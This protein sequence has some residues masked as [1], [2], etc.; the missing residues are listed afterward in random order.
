LCIFDNIDGEQKTITTK[1]FDLSELS[2]SLRF[3]SSDIKQ[4][5]QN[6]KR[7]HEIKEVWCQIFE[8]VKHYKVFNFVIEELE[9]KNKTNTNKNSSELNKQSKNLWHRTLTINLIEKNCN[10]IGLKLIPIIPAYS[11]FIGN[12]IHT[13]YV[14]PIAS[15]IEIGRRG[16]VKYLKGN[17]IYPCISLI[18][19]EKLLSLLG[20]ND[21]K[22][23]DSWTQLYR[24]I[25]R[26]RYR[27]VL[28]LDNVLSDK[29]LGNYK[30]KIRVITQ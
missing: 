20:E 30:S 15:A 29:Y 14:D 22:T 7:K 10:E 8:L 5:K 17:S 1:L 16:M 21:D 11:S 3:S 23:C 27:N 26:K 2:T 19:Q 24:I 13:S 9:F 28:S 4:V 18:N 6:N 25:Y 12:M